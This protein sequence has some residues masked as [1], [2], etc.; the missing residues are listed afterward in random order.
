VSDSR[1]GSV[2]DPTRLA[3]DLRSLSLH[4]H[5]LL[6]QPTISP[7]QFLKLTE[8]VT[9]LRVSLESSPETAVKRWVVNLERA[10]RDRGASETPRTPSTEWGNWSQEPPSWVFTRA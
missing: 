2:K 3:N 7:S 8:R 9:E 10:I 6:R 5:Q 4:A 1:S